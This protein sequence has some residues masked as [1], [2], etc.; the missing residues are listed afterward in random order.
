MGEPEI[1]VAIVTA[2]DTD[3]TGY[4]AWRDWYL[5]YIRDG[6]PS[7]NVS[8]EMLSTFMSLLHPVKHHVDYQIRA[9]M[10]QTRMPDE[11]LV[12]S[13]VP[14]PDVDFLPDSVVWVEPMLS[15]RELELNPTAGMLC[16]PDLEDV[17][18]RRER[19][20]SLGCSDKNTVLVLCKTE[21]LMVLDDC[22]LPGPGLVEAAYRSC[23]EG[24]VLLPAH[25]QL[26]YP[27]E[28]RP[29]VEIADANTDLAAGHLVMGIW[30]APLKFFLDI[31][32]WNTDLDGCRGGLDL[33]LRVRMDRYLEMRGGGYDIF[34][35]ARVYEIGHDYPWGKE[36]SLDWQEKIPSGYVAPGPSLKKVREKIFST[37]IEPSDDG[38]MTI[39]EIIDEICDAEEEEDED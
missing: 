21:Y 14:H 20:V 32:G 24:K 11:I 23:Q 27:T 30:A 13:R 35:R 29:Y 6:G 7:K 15:S 22:C 2:R 17:P 9:L 31:N 4:A 25:R 12:V 5:S 1:T 10:N 8:A 36:S 19:G 38:D 33:E 37:W 28:D 26:Y 3:E 16:H 34:S 18:G 39:G